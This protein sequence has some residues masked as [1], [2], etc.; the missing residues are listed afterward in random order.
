MSYFE[1]RTHTDELIEII[2]SNA[3]TIIDAVKELHSTF[4]PSK[5]LEGV[6]YYF[7]ENNII[8]EPV[9]TYDEVGNKVVD[10][11]A[12]EEAT[13]IPAGFHKIL[14]DQKVGY[15]AGEP[16]SFGSKSDNK[17][18]LALVDELIGEEFEDTLPEL[19]LNASNKGHEWLHVYVD[20]DGEFQHLIIPA[21]EFIPIYDKKRKDKLIAGLRF[22]NDG[23]NVVK[24]EL[25]TP[26]DVV[27]FEM[28]NGQIH[29]DALEE[30]NPAPH[31]IQGD[32][33]M[34]WRDV[35]FIE[36]KNNN[37]CVSDLHFI[38][39][40]VDA[41][42]KLVSETQN[43]LEDIQAL[44]YVLK[45]YEGTDL[46]EFKTQLKRYRVIKTEADEGSGVDTL[47]AEVPVEAYKTHSEKLKDSIYSFGQGVNPSPDII[48]DAPSGVALQNL[49]SLLDI[50]ASML[51]RK[52]TLALRK[53]MWFVA[54]YAE[55]SKKGKFDYR[56]I[57]FAFN[58][59]ILTNEAEI[60]QMCR[61]SEGV[62][63]KTTQLE[64][65]PWVKDVSLEKQRLEEDAKLYGDDLE[66][67]DEDGDDDGPTGD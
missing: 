48:G 61:D 66:P 31:F 6:N 44:I 36:F 24:L 37:A 7:N 16:L 17:E 1:G 38:K 63:S 59:M 23:P 28:I 9:Y 33:A 67:L 20:E 65:H 19:I 62:I 21:E 56:D 50:K 27:Y 22:Y 41:Y 54:K 10:R 64:N 39:R 30:K 15:L 45:G 57:T 2:N 3:P 5:Y 32:K 13:R 51:E 34:S 46:N 11:E 18:T 58:K 35:P 49:Y 4:N 60:I 42:D 12:T 43:T 52:F 29:Y 25:W 53:F 40:H 8:N 14:V 26:D 55:L 47:K